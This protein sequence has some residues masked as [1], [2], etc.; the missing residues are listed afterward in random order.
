MNHFE[1]SLMKVQSCHQLEEQ[2]N[3]SQAN[4]PSITNMGNLHFYGWTLKNIRQDQSN[5]S[6]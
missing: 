3:S 5:R 1:E 6:S 2:C 4:L